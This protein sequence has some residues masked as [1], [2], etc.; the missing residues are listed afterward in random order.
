[1]RTY[2]NCLSLNISFKDPISKYSHILSDW[3]LGIQRM[4]STYEIER[5]QFQPIKGMKKE[6]KSESK[7]TDD[8]EIKLESYVG[9]REQE[10]QTLGWDFTPAAA[11]RK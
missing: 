10:P 7:V 5:T 4:N 11:A 3:K 6:F 9:T 8:W 2:F 1:M